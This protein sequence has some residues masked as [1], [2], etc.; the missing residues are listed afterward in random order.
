MQVK[1]KGRYGRVYMAELRSKEVG[2]KGLE[3]NVKGPKEAA[4][5][6]DVRSLA[7]EAKVMMAIGLHPNVLGLIGVVI[8]N[9]PR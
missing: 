9:M 2:G 5:Y 1:S 6:D 4:K 3:V 8:E 7:D